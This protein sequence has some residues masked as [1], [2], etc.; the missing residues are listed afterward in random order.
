MTMKYAKRE[1]IRKCAVHQAIYKACAER[2]QSSGYFSFDDVMDDAGFHGIEQGAVR[3]DY[4]RDWLQEDA[5]CELVP[6][7]RE[8]FMSKRA[9]TANGIPPP[10]IAPERYIAGGRKRTCGFANVTHCNGRLAIH[11]LEW[12]RAVA[13]GTA[14][15]ANQ[16]AGQ[17]ID[18]N[19]ITAPAITPLLNGETQQ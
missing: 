11:R 1:E 19:L 13:A 10:E 12:K 4:I 7:S 3:F 14:R 15:A 16:Y 17:L 2:L 5:G 8:W 6:L 9:R 18:R